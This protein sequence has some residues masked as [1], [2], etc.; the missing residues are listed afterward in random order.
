MIA[1]LNILCITRKLMDCNEQIMNYSYLTLNSGY[2]TFF[3]ARTA[4]V[5]RG[6]NACKY[7][8]NGLIYKVCMDA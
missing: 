3:I 1:F 7:E 6:D 2:H 4:A 5:P 8:I